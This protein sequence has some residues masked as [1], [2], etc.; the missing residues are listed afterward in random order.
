MECKYS[1]KGKLILKIYTI[2]AKI[3]SF[4]FDLL[5]I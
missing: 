4:R 5:I 1:L 2:L 3:Y